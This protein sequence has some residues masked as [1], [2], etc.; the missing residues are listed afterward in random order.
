MK[1]K[2]FNNF[3]TDTPEDIT[4]KLSLSLLDNFSKNYSEFHD[5]LTKSKMFLEEFEGL[6]EE[7]KTLVKKDEFESTLASYII[8]V[9]EAIASLKETLNSVKNENVTI[10]NENAKTISNKLKDVVDII[11]EEIRQQKRV[12]NDNNLVTENKI[13]KILDIANRVDV[14]LVETKLDEFTL[15]IKDIKEKVEKELPKAKL[16][17]NDHVYENKKRLEELENKQ[18]VSVSVI[19]NELTDID[20]KVVQLEEKYSSVNEQLPKIKKEIL[21]NSSLLEKN[22]KEEISFVRIKLEEEISHK[23]SQILDTFKNTV[24]LQNLEL[25]KLNE[26]LPKQRSRITDAELDVKKAVKDITEIKNDRSLFKRLNEVHREVKTVDGL[27]EQNNEKLKDV[28][29]QIRETISKVNGALNEEKYYAVN[30]KIEHIEEVL[31]KLDE[32][33]LLNEEIFPNPSGK[34]KDPLTPLDQN[35]VTFE[36][37]QKHYSLFINRIQQQLMTLGGGGSSK[38][39]DLD[40]TDYYSVK[41]PADGNVLKYV[42][43]NA[44]WEAGVVS[45]GSSFDQNLNT[46]NSVTFASLTTTGDVVV[47]GNLSVLG[48]TTVINSATLTIED[49]NIVL[50][51]GS[52]D[53]A[54]SN[55]AGI[56]VDGA[57]ANIVYLSSGDKWQLNK[58]L[59]VLGDISA[60]GTIT[61]PYFYS[62]SDISLKEDV[63]PIDNALDKVLNLFGVSFR[64]KSN[65]QDSIGLIAQDVEKVIPEI[66]KRNALGNKTVSYDSIVPLLVEAIKEQQKQIEYLKKKI[67]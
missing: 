61:S 6:S 66:V 47:T 10:V 55:G 29:K 41:N 52:P 63:S 31:K 12:I 23:E 40:D 54:T 32:K 46:T 45:A 8:I 22:L 56:T 33:K 5:N 18:N 43:A 11:N 50:A 60:T 15:S 51:N 30:K 38:L 14:D 58:D 62:E 26:E 65:K 28:E 13:N 64:W 67:K 35:F 49:K 19:S 39:W 9:N 4:N 59:D 7:L 42:S 21:S 44:K 27:I 57:F 20:R 16:I 48:N 2:Q 36:Q 37:L 3:Q 1:L 25:E 17:F 53:A 24:S 34:T